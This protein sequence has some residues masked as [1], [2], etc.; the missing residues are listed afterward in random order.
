[1]G[2]NKMSH[3][4]RAEGIILIWGEGWQELPVRRCSLHRSS[5]WK[6]KF[7]LAC[8]QNYSSLGLMSV[9]G[10][11]REMRPEISEQTRKGLGFPLKEGY[12]EGTR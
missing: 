4:P 7:M 12:F 1:M 11:R 3:R 6:R 5:R 8:M 9:R 2:T 10:E